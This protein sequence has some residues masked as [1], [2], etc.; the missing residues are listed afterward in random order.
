MAEAESV[1]FHVMIYKGSESFCLS[2]KMTSIQAKQIA[3]AYLFEKITAISII[4]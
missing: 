2:L 1:I 3:H 4:W